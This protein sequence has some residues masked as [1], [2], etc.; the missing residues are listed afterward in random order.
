MTYQPVVFV[1]FFPF[2]VLLCYLK[3]L[4]RNRN[5]GVELQK[6]ETGIPAELEK[7]LGS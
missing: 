6:N 2:Y 3:R 4:S 5:T 7:T 1:K